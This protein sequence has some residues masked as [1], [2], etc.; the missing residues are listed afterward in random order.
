MIIKKKIIDVLYYSIRHTKSLLQLCSL[1]LISDE[2]SALIDRIYQLP[3]KL[4]NGP[5]PVFVDETGE[6]DP[7]LLPRGGAR[8]LGH[9]HPAGRGGGGGGGAVMAEGRGGG[10]SPCN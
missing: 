2:V 1:Y 5:L 8:R 9:C 10:G 7:W 3:S 6:H 4:S